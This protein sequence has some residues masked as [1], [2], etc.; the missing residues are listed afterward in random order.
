MDGTVTNTAA[1]H[2]A[3]WKRL[4]DGFLTNIS[5]RTGGRQ[6]PF[7]AD[8]YRLFVDGKPRDDGIRDFLASREIALPEGAPDDPPG[9]ET[10]VGL[11]KLKNRYFLERLR[12]GGPDTYPSSVALVRALRERGVR[13]AIISASRNMREVLDSAGVRDLFEAHVDGI[14]AARLD[15]RGKPDPAVFLE[16][17]RRLH[18]A[19]ERTMVVEDALAGVEAARRGGFAFVLGV[20]RAG[21]PGELIARGADLV[22]HD[23]SEASV[24]LPD[25]AAVAAVAVDLDALPRDAAPRLRRRLAQ[26]VRLGIDVVVVSAGRVPEAWSRSVAA[27]PGAWW[28]ITSEADSHLL[29]ALADH[30]PGRDEPEQLL[31]LGHRRSGGLLADVHARASGAA[32]IAIDPLAVPGAAPVDPDWAEETLR[33]VGAALRAPPS[34]T[35]DPLW[36]LD[37]PG[38]DPLREREVESWLTVANGRV[39]TRGSVEEGSGRSASATYVAAMFGWPRR[40][41]G[42]PELA[43]GPEWTRL[44]PRIGDFPLQLESGDIL[45]HLR[46]LDFRQA[47]L[48]RDWRHRAT[49]GLETHLRSERFASLVDR[50]ILALEAWRA[51]GSRALRLGDDIPLPRA[52]GAISRVRATR[53]STHLLVAVDARRVG[54]T[55]FA[56]GTA[57]RGGR[58]RRIM[59]VSRSFDGMAPSR[60]APMALRRTRR[61]GISRVRAAH[62]R[63]WRSRWRD[64]DVVIEGDDFAQRS[65]RFAAYHLISS[66]E[67]G[68]GLAS[69]A[70]RGLTGPGYRGHVFWDTEVFMLPFFIHTHPDTA[71]SLLA[72]RYHRLPEARRR[73]RARGYRGAHFPWES[74]GTG[75][76]VTPAYATDPQGERVDILTGQQEDHITADIAWAVWRYWQATGDEAFLAD[77]GAEIVLET[78][79]F[80]ASRARCGSDGRHHIEKVIGPDEYHEGVSDNAFTQVMAR[81]NLERGVEL[82]DILARRDPGLWR[83]ISDRLRIGEE[84]V[85]GWGEV[86]SG[87][88][89]GFDASSLLYE[90]FAG[91]F[92]L[93]D[94]RIAD[95]SARPVA[96]DVLLARER[97]ARSQVVKQA[98]VLMLAFMLPELMPRHVVDANYRYY[99]PRT[100]HGSSLSPPVHAVVAARCG[101]VADALTYFRMSAQ[102]D[103]GSEM[104]NAAYGVHM[105]TLGG[106]WQA[107]VFGFGGARPEGPGLRLDPHLPAGWTR[108][109][110]P[111]MWRGGRLRVH[112]THD[113]VRL[114]LDRVTEIAL[115]SAPAIA[116]EPGV[117]TAD[118][119]RGHWSRL[120]A[121][122]R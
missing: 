21:H 85:R 71:R 121:G 97:V 113:A 49:N 4:F 112:A 61:D 84:E 79:R 41:E 55:A 68:S 48:F 105:A 107:A 83:S 99:E 104:G 56:I 66:A 80:W 6:R 87:L 100:A 67:P 8:D 101:H 10:V 94:I 40:H 15:L 17:A 53:R 31:V 81:W 20:D 110:F 70:A 93:K 98:D 69:I 34:P 14:E 5:G 86:A 73:A 44:F 118:H 96:A 16:A 102:I 13:T 30:L 78:S 35:G 23:L 22:V 91:F 72:Y 52:E 116:L 108:L 32:T 38:F 120:T 43:V 89:D 24:E 115:G 82:A 45:G 119:W 57:E 64:A 62:R 103:L 7:S 11:G 95:Q 54:S 9:S 122:E 74:A 29:D 88:C 3:A 114:E 59:A 42:G 25:P 90:Q 65:V 39:G 92:G 76:E 60:D 77:M 46:I 51:G 27:G 26:L 37:I 50:R 12:A 58:L 117:Y 18:V 111:F 19:P 28:A 75:A 36:R 1:V 109:S 63:A 2:M 33:A 106:L 47:I